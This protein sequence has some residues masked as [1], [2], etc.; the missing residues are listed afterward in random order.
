MNVNQRIVGGKV[1]QVKPR[2]ED[3]NGFT[4]AVVK[5]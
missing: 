2:D 1:I 5:C 4:N 3:S